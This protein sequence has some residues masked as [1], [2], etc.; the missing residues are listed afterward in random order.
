MWVLL[1]VEDGKIVPS[2]Y[3]KAVKAAGL[4]IITWTIERL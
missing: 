2:K 4:D 3:A 1:T